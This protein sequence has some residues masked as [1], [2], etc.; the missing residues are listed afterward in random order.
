MSFS[1]EIY[2]PLRPEQF[3]SLR[4]EHFTDADFL[5]RTR[6]FVCFEVFWECL[7]EH[8]GNAFAHNSH[9]VDRVHKRFCVGLE[10]VSCGERNH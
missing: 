8:Q 3:F 6:A 2:Y 1:R 10:Q 7:L 4:N 5:Q 9:G